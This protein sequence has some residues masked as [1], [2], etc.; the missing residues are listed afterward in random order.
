MDVKYK[1]AD[2]RE[3]STIAINGFDVEMLW[4]SGASIS[5]MSEECWK[6][7]GS[8]ILIDNRI[9]LCGVF[10]KED[11]KPVGSVKLVVEWNKKRRE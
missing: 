3:W 4:D 5:V 1:K 8:P 9:R 10:S 11:E 2:E 7:I 6:M